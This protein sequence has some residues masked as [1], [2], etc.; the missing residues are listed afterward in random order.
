M[1]SLMKNKKGVGGAIW[2]IIVILV[3]ITGF[4]GYFAITAGPSQKIV[5]QTAQDIAEATKK[6]DVASIGIY[7]RDLENNNINTKVAVPVYCKETDG[8]FIIDATSSSTSAE[9]TGKSTIGKE[10]TCWAFNTTYQSEP[11]T[12]IVDEESEHVVIDAYKV[13]GT[14]TIDFY[15]DTYTTGT[16][17]VINVTAGADA[18]D[19]FQKMRF[20]NSGTDMAYNLGGFYFNTIEG[21]NVSVIDISGSATLSGMDH[22]SAQIVISSLSTKVSARKDSWDFAFEIDD[23]SAT[24][25]NQPLYMQENDYLES[26]SVAVTADGDGCTSGGGDLISSYAFAKGYYRSSKE[27][28]VNFGHETDATSPSVIGS[29]VTGDTFYCS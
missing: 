29:D 4:V 5:Q 2:A 7:V 10:I 15:D 1:K 22:S 25:G 21:T 6:G 12:L 17:G 23:D 19:T 27:N 9:I 26:G 14:G 18:T 8:E 13:V 3:I 28:T 20:T 16:A 24:A 11:K